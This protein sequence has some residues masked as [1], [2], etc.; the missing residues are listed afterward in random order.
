MNTEDRMSPC[1]RGCGA[2]VPTDGPAI[3]GSCEAG[4]QVRAHEA[5][6]RTAERDRLVFSERQAGS[7]TIRTRGYAV[8]LVVPPADEPD[9][10]TLFPVE[11]QRLITQL[12]AALDFVLA[13]KSPYKDGVT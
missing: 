10:R 7:I 3:C 13:L 1:F 11:A 5:A 12:T 6:A 4:D 2:F 9:G 8:Y